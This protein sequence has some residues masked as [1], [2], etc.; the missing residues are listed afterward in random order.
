MGLTER[1]GTSPPEWSDYALISLM[2][3]SITEYNVKWLRTKIRL[4]QQVSGQVHYI[5][6]TPRTHTNLDKGPD[7]VER[8]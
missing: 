8:D 7:T 4:V 5:L 1:C 6:G 3:R 2:G